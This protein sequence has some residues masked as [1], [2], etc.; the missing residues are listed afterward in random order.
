MAK[1]KSKKVDHI[2]FTQLSMLLRCGEQYR[3]R[4]VLGKKNPPSGSLIRGRC[5][6][7]AEAD[8]FTAKIKTKKYLST[9]AVLDAYSDE[10][11]ENKGQIAWHRDELDGKS[12]KKAA[13]QMK[14][15]GIRLIKVFNR[16]QLMNCNPIEIESEFTVEFEGGCKP[17]IGRFDRIDKYDIIAE[18]KFVK[19]SPH[20]QDIIKDV[21]M[22][23]YDLGYRAK[24]GKSPKMLMKQWAVDTAT[25]KT[26]IQ[27]CPPRPNDA[28]QRFLRRLEAAMLTIEKGN[29]LPA[30]N[31]AWACNPKYCG[32]YSS[33]RVRP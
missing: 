25:A 10:W 7:K 30:A 18:E 17:M 13:G 27:K 2:S 8:N 5:C 26:V 15:S 6:H 11:E 1:A 14:D 21:Q 4:Y 3:Q 29:F 32:Y 20:S 12:P 28:I 31:D 9:D 23:A 16:Q 33:C 19:K 24:Y 22:T